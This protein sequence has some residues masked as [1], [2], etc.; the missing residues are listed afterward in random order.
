MATQ[1]YMGRGQLVDRLTAQVGSPE[2]AKNI[3]VKRG[4]MD[5]NGNLTRKGLQRNNMTAEERAKDR[6]S[7]RLGIPPSRLSYN[8]K[9][10]LATKKKS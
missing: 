4:Q 10:N 8:P 1:K 7:K 9:T 5:S 2:L 3:L 6:S